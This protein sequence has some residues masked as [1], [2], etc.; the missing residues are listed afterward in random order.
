M[1]RNTFLFLRQVVAELYL[2]WC[3]AAARYNQTLYQKTVRIVLQPLL[4]CCR[5]SNHL[6]PHST[7]HFLD[8]PHL[9]QEHFGHSDSEKD[10]NFQ[11]KGLRMLSL[12]KHRKSHLLPAPVFVIASQN[13]H[14]TQISQWLGYFLHPDNAVHAEWFLPK[15]DSLHS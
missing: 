1:D 7:D 15:Q 11:I 5:S 9:R 8:V 12:S 14:Y 13:H 2:P 6:P 10:L 4:Y 3:S